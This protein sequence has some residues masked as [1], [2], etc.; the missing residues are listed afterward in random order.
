[1]EERERRM[2]E[3]TKSMEQERGKLE[4]SKAAAA[5]TCCCLPGGVGQLPSSPS[6]IKT[7][8]GGRRRR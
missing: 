1:M 8:D 2:V 5:A 7:K 3:L 6:V 4:K